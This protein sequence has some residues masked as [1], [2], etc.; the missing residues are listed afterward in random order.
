MSKLFF[1]IFLENWITSEDFATKK[2]T[3]VEH[4]HSSR[5][6]LLRSTRDD[7]RRSQSQMKGLPVSSYYLSAFFLPRCYLWVIRIRIDVTTQ[8]G[9]VAKCMGDASK[10]RGR[11]VAITRN[12]K[13][14]IRLIGWKGSRQPGLGVIWY[15]TLCG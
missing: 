9:H 10:S 14:R 12:I 11:H 7:T 8:N 15:S 4:M 1:C 3:K 6:Y 5:A 2:K 13:V